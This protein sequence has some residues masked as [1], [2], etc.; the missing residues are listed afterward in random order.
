MTAIVTSEAITSR[1]TLFNK[2]AGLIRVGEP[3]TVKVNVRHEQGSRMA[4]DVTQVSN[5]SRRGHSIA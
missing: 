5:T 3:R 1:P 4:A 2:V